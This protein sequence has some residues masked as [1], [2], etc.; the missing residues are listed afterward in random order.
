MLLLLQHVRKDQIVVFERIQWLCLDAADYL[1]RSTCGA[2]EEYICGPTCL[3][4][5]DY[6]P[7]LCTADC[8]FGCFCKEGYVRRSNEA[9]SP[10]VK[11]EE[12]EEE[13]PKRK[14]CKNQEYSSC[15]SA[16]PF[17]CSDLSFPLPKPIRAC[18]AVCKIGCVCKEGFYRLGKKCVAPERCCTGENERFTTCGTACPETCNS[19][20]RICTK[21]CVGGCFCASSD[22][23]R[24]D[25]STNSPCIPRKECPAKT[26]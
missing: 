5:C 3:E 13:K 18:P 12:C 7:E 9:G 14:C 20:P 21:Q 15:G 10:C 2:N 26:Y 19:T 17:T 23:V 16:C 22:F 8:R 6:K 24:R 4:T 25:N 11:R 1:P